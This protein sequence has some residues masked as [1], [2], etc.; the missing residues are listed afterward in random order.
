MPK[1]LIT[2]PDYIPTRKV[3]MGQAVGSLVTIAAWM[4]ETYTTLDI[5]LFIGTAALQLI[6]FIAQ[7]FIRD[8]A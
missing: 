4:L 8:S 3:G 7:Y 6:M 5:P 1:E 2:Q